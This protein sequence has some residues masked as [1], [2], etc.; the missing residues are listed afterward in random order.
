MIPL[1]HDLIILEYQVK[2]SPARYDSVLPLCAFCFGQSSSNNNV[3][4]TQHW[5]LARTLVSL[6]LYFC[7]GH[8]QNFS[9]LAMILNVRVL[10]ENVLIVCTY[11]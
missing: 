5:D 7:H 9:D 4:L 6:Q 8:H 11:I 3:A 2:R 1:P 10:N